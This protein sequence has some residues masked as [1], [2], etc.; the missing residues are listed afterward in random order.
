MGAGLLARL[1]GLTAL[2]WLAGLTAAAAAN[3][4]QLDYVGYIAGAPVLTLNANITVP[5]GTKPHDGGYTITADIA[6][7]GNLAVLYPYAQSV[8]AAG[9]LVGGR[10]AP[11][12]YL[13]PGRGRHPSRTLRPRR[14][15]EHRQPYRD[16]DAGIRP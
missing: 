11:A 4:A 7:M 15:D 3:Q 10:C 2:A 5:E 8:Q 6:T 16:D 12:R 13:G 14:P 1:G 9:A